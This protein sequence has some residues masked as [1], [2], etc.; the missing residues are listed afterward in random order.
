MDN[1]ETAK[2]TVCG[3]EIKDGVCVGCGKPA[4]ET[5]STETEAPIA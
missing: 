5:A 3:G 1:N 2:C 4:E